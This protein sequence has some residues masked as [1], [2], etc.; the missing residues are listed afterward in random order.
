MVCSKQEYY[1]EMTNAE[2]QDILMRKKKKVQLLK[3][4]QEKLSYIERRMMHPGQ[5]SEE[6]DRLV[7]EVL[8]KLKQQIEENLYFLTTR[9]ASENAIML[10]NPGILLPEELQK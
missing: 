10:M 4:M 7:K 3:Q 9:K 8:M 1:T 6:R 5:K 2:K